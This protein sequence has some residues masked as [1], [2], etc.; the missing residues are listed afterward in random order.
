MKVDPPTA[1]LN[2]VGSHSLWRIAL[3]LPAGLQN[4]HQDGGRMFLFFVADPR[5]VPLCKL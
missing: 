1:L 3:P 5:T 2:G 4:S